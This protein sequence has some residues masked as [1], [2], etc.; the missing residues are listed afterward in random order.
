M[1]NP[2][3]LS[4]L[5]IMNENYIQKLK[6]STLLITKTGQ[7]VGV[8]LKVNKLF[9]SKNYFTSLSWFYLPVTS[10][11]TV[12]DIPDRSQTKPKP[13]VSVNF[14]I[15][16]PAYG[17]SKN[18]GITGLRNLGNTCYINAILQCLSRE[19]EKKNESWIRTDES[20]TFRLRNYFWQIK[21]SIWVG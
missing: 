4:Y 10:G 19:N 18:R 9:K 11:T 14:D 13:R 21:T 1:L 7:L 12:P 2:Q 20:K 15:L 6:D 5:K 17:S 16:S 8:P 3:E